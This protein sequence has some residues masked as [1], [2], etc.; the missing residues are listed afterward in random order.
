M[1]Q[2]TKAQRPVDLAV[3]GVVN[4][5]KSSL[6]NALARQQVAETSPVGGT[7]T[8]VKATGWREVVAEIGPVAVR[9]IDTP[10]LEEVGDEARERLALE[11]ARKADLIIFITAEDL[12]ASA[13]VAIERLRVVGK[14]I[15][16]AVNKMDL[17]DPEEQEEVL[18]KIRGRLAGTIA[19]EDVVGIAAA[20]LVRKRGPDG[21]IETTRGEPEVEPLETRILACL[22][23]AAGDLQALA[24]A[25]GQ[26]EAHRQVREADRVRR[27]E[28]AERV[29]DET[30]VALALALAVN[31]IPVLDLLTGSGGIALLVKRVGSVYDADL[32][33]ESLQQLS[34]DLIRGGRIALW[35]SLAATGLGGALKLVPGLGHAAGALTQAT[36][37][38]YFGHVLGR[39][40]VTYFENGRDWGDAGL[41]ALLD[42][43]AQA[44][45]RRTLTRGLADRLK[46]RLASRSDE[47]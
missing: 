26:V 37:A 36:A 34:R 20:P 5:G 29:A 21:R 3:F 23:E 8:E 32:S 35:G 15:V 45:D 4:A 10:G 40:L 25:S 28:R 38:G 12:T 39:A 16:V 18:S 46:A 7:T 9:L 19:A 33:A 31:P 42:R 41:V 6:I 2:P 1:S 17:L 11:A 43:L 27:R 30:S 24:D 13:Q 14:P 22:A 47:S 44:T